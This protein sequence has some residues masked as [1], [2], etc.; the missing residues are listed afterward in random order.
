MYLCLFFM[1]D[2]RFSTFFGGP[3][4]YSAQTTDLMNSTSTS[5]NTIYKTDFNYDIVIQTALNESVSA[6][7]R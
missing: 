6:R 1:L 5:I 4:Y 2:T 7:T 3:T